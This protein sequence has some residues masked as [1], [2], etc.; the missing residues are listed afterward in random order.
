MQRGSCASSTRLHNLLH[1]S[2]HARTQWIVLSCLR[3]TQPV[4]VNYVSC[5]VGHHVVP[6]LPATSLAPHSAPQRT[7]LHHSARS[8]TTPASAE[9]APWQCGRAR[10]G[11]GQGRFCSCLQSLGGTCTSSMPCTC[12]SCS[13]AAT[14]S[15]HGRGG[16]RCRMVRP[17]R[18]CCTYQAQGV[19]SRRPCL[20]PAAA[21]PG[22]T[23]AFPLPKA[24]TAMSLLLLLPP[25]PPLLLLGGS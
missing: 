25:L 20:A 19:P 4:W 3:P 8:F 23:N 15:R 21:A 7:Q 5:N 16:A 10:R 24:H 18:G 6:D 11:P 17:R 14:R 22:Q 9:R 12:G 13:S 1:C 2:T